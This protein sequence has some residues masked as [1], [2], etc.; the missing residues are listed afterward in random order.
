MNKERLRWAL[1]NPE[2]S[3]VEESEAQGE[4]GCL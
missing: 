1:K 3:P 4:E 2:K